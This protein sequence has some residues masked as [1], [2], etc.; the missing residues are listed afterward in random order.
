[1]LDESIGKKIARDKSNEKAA[2]SYGRWHGVI[3]VDGI[4]EGRQRAGCPPPR[5]V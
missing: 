5:N 3:V 4:C 2:V 1:M